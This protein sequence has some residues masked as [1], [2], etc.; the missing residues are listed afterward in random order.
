[1]LATEGKYV[2]EVTSD[3]CYQI[4]CAIRS[5][6]EYAIRNHWVNHLDVDWHERERGN[7]D[8]MKRFYTLS[9][10]PSLFD[11]HMSDLDKIIKEAKVLSN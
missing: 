1:M 4:A 2:I 5:R 6:L 7:I 8:M 3:E 11:S 9:L 10:H